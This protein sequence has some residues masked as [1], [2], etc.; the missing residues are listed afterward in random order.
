MNKLVRYVPDADLRKGYTGL[1]E[2]APLAKLKRGEFVVFVNRRRDKL[3]MCT[4][5]D[6]VLYLRMPSGERIDPKTIQFLPECFEGSVIYYNKAVEKS[7]KK[8]YPSWFEKA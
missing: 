2:T 7:L 4:E 6:M 1:S 3:K 5:K 8:Y